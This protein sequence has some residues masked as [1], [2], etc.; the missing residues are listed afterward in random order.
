MAGALRDSALQ[1][2]DDG[3]TSDGDDVEEPP[4]SIVPYKV[5]VR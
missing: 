3:D 4:S 2:L 5:P 1:E